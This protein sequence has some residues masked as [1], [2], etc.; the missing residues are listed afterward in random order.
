MMEK[1]LKIV[2]KMSNLK[3]SSINDIFEKSG[4]GRFMSEREKFLLEQEKKKKEALKLKLPERVAAKDIIIGYQKKIHYASKDFHEDLLRTEYV[5]SDEDQDGM[6][7]R[8]E[9]EF[10][11]DHRSHIFVTGTISVVV[12]KPHSDNKIMNANYHANIRAIERDVAWEKEMIEIETVMREK[13]AEFRKP[14]IQL[15]FD[16]DKPDYGA[17]KNNLPTYSI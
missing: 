2:V 10:N 15:M 6:L 1:H 11:Y 16:A 8:I 17:W 5:P 4:P 13:E 9:D 12:N 3:F 14:G 7:G